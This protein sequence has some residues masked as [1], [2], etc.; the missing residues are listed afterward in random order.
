[1]P[2]PKEAKNDQIIRELPLIRRYSRYNETE[3]YRFRMFLKNRL[4]MPGK[5]LDALVQETTDAVWE[6][7]D[8]TTCAHCCRA[9]E[10]VVDDKDIRRLADRFKITVQQFA[11]KYVTVEADKSKRF[12]A[13]PCPFLGD[14]NRC[15]VYEDRPQACRDYP[16]LHKDGFRQRTLSMIE[17][18]ESCPI[19]FNVWERLKRR[20]WRKGG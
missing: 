8:C 10:I 2:D 6:Q 16:Y 20:L 15:T 3:N 13:V 7:I 18:A 4:N 19:V 14:D 9:Y 11:R 17:N 5:E 1:M 12:S